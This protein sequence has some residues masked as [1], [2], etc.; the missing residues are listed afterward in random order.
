MRTS[1]ARP[2]ASSAGLRTLTLVA[3]IAVL[4]GCGGGESGSAVK[5]AERA[6]PHEVRLD[7]G[8]GRVSIGMRS[9]GVRR[10]GSPQA[11]DRPKASSTLE[12]RIDARSVQVHYGNKAFEFGGESPA[13]PYVQGIEVTGE[14]FE[15]RLKD[16]E[17]AKLASGYE[18]VKR[19]LEGDGHRVHT[20]D[21]DGSKAVWV[22]MPL[23]DPAV[24]DA[25][26]VYVATQFF[27][28]PGDEPGIFMLAGSKAQKFSCS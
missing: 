2:R 27:F 11:A 7:S 6:D 15:V 10:L 13:D 12:Y 18:Q 1:R 9:S 23:A 5:A 16:G 20:L 4:G 22:K 17:T 24:V 14:A 3:A 26:D 8:I 21:C 28:R 25:D 19:R